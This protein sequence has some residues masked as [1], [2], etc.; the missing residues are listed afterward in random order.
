MRSR[1]FT[2]AIVAGE[3][4]G[5]QLG[6]SLINQ[7]KSME[8][9][10]E[11]VG[12]GGALMA[13]E[14]FP[15]SYDMETLSVNGFFDPI[16]RLPALI[17]LMLKLRKE[18]IRKRPNCF[19]GIDSNFFNLML[20][21]FLKKKGIKTIQYVS[22]SI[23]A[24][25]QGRVKKIARSVDMVLTLY[26]FEVTVFK[27]NSVKAKFVGHPVASE[28]LNLDY[29]TLKIE[30]RRDLKISPDK[31][32]VA[33]LPGSRRSEV[34]R[35]G[36]DF[37]ETAIELREHVDKFLIPAANPKRYQQLFSM[38]GDFPELQGKVR[39][40]E[41]NSKKVMS[42]SDV[43]LVNSG[44]ATLEAM[45]L[46]KP[47][48]MSYRL[49]KFTHLL[50]SKLVRTNLFALPNILAGEKIVPEFLQDEAEPKKMA[51][52]IK[53]FLGRDEQAELFSK[54]HEIHSRLCGSGVS[55]NEASRAV[56][57]FCKEN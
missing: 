27:E 42:A 46:R 41:G 25:R 56:L 11:F 7:I 4:S 1:P 39:L 44:T 48:V 5:D 45:L 6:A 31:K 36:R 35:S 29:E 52:A 57:K 18:I 30:A 20:A 43:V 34:A 51:K 16:I 49:G 17:K 13:A 32:V 54:Y 8:P 22:P 37:L 50:V 9:E 10:T 2:I 55:G 28:Y 12:V 14:G 33:I 3:A 40:F 19:V 38:L 53:R 47:M 21:G 26:P 23:W 24:W 15:E